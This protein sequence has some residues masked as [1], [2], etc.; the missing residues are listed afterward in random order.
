MSRVRW[1]WMVGLSYFLV[2]GCAL[3]AF[4]KP[5]FDRCGEDFTDER[6]AQTRYTKFTFRHRATTPDGTRVDTS[7]K[8]V[9]LEL[10]DAIRR[11]VENCLQ[12]SI[13]A[14]AYRVKIAEQETVCHGRQVF[15][16][17]GV[18][19]NVIEV[20]SGEEEC[21]GCTDVV[22]WGNTA[23]CTTDLDMLGHLIVHMAL[24][25]S[26]GNTAETMP[27]EFLCGDEAMAMVRMGG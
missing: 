12:M 7:G 14:C 1:A 13:P 16:C 17:Q 6:Y 15:E 23:V 25:L 9:D 2:S 18:M 11:Q 5:L 26:H 8:N 27:R 24:R 21:G 20:A 10:A 19:P 4:T 3:L 22:E